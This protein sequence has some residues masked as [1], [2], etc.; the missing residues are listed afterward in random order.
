MNERVTAVLHRLRFLMA[1]P[2]IREISPVCKGLGNMDEGIS[3]GKVGEGK[4]RDNIERKVYRPGPDIL[5][6]LSA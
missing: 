1:N 3:H 4:V 6:K 2:V 5:G